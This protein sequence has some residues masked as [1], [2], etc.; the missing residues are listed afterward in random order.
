MEQLLEREFVESIL[1]EVRGEPEGEYE[2]R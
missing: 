2:E 1:A